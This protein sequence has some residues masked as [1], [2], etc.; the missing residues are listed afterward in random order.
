ME[1]EVKYFLFYCG[2]TREVCWTIAGVFFN[3]VKM[4]SVDFLL[5]CLK[6]DNIEA[7]FG[8]NTS[9]KQQ[10][11]VKK[12]A[13]KSH[14]K[15]NSGSLKLSCYQDYWDWTETVAQHEDDI[16]L[17]PSF[18]LFDRYYESF[19]LARCLISHLGK[20]VCAAQAIIWYAFLVRV[21]VWLEIS[22]DCE[23]LYCLLP[24][25]WRNNMDTKEE[26][27]NIHTV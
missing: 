24:T 27:K 13:R 1:Y 23:L 16:S 2:G 18:A 22:D 26:K 4:V 20:V 11:R 21:T 8:K 12:M 7:C 5:N 9:S 17:Y 14:I 15:I 25:K 3:R 10:L 6:W 19:R